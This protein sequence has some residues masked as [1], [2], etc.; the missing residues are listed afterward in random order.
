MY[1]KMYPNTLI[2]LELD[3]LFGVL[4]SIGCIVCIELAG[5]PNNQAGSSVFSARG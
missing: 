5:L 2:S 4:P 1:P 3:D